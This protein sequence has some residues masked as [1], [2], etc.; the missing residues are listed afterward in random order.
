MKSSWK[1]LYHFFLLFL[2][3]ALLVGLAVYVYRNGESFERLKQIDL[4]IIALL[5]GFHVV[6]YLLLGITH[7]YPLSKY[8]VYL[9][10]KDWYGLATI[11]EMFNYLLPARGGS[12]IRLL[13]LHDKY[14]ISKRELLSM[15]LAVV[16]TGF[17]MLGI[18]GAIYCHLFLSHINPLFYALEILYVGVTVSSLIFVFASDFVIS[19][20][21]MDAKYSPKK[22]LVDK[23]IMGVSSLCYL[24]M[25]LINPIKIYL[26]FK[27]IGIDLG[28]TETIEMSLILLASSFFQVVPGNIGVKEMATAYIGKQYGIQFETALLASLIDRS[29]M[30][31][32]L[33]PV[34][35]YSYWSLMLK[36]SFSAINLQSSGA[37]SRIPLIKRLVKLRW[38]LLPK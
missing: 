32:F 9:K 15:G 30:M 21:K 20:L 28:L 4:S 16:M 38:P 34:G 7:A 22:Y 1:T 11:S 14:H 13:Y 26:S 35:F 27:A 17:L 23:K 19:L 6:N 33:F 3:L 2:S 36:G 18:F 25:L 8:G 12:A 24:G 37:S 29:I 31:L 5:I 10:F